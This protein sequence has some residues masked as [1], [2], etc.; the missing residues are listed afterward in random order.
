MSCEQI[1]ELLSAYLDKQLAPQEHLQVTDHLHTCLLC[2][3]VFVDF[4]RFDAL[5]AG[6][7]RVK[8]HP[9]LYDAIF[10]SAEYHELTGTA[11]FEH[12]ALRSPHPLR[13]TATSRP[14]LVVLPGGRTPNSPHSPA[15]P[16]SQDVRSRPHPPL[17]RLLLPCLA[18]YLLLT[19]TLDALQRP[20]TGQIHTEHVPLSQRQAYRLSRKCLL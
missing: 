4:R 19:L 13:H 1:K 3:K 8:P 16:R 14:Q 2:K 12:F 7:P 10:F 17:L 9:S 20:D 18:A 6:L 5:L 11:G 15:P